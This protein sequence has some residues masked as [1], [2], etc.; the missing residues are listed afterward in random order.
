V[1]AQIDRRTNT[2][3]CVI[4]RV[5]ARGEGIWE[6]ANAARRHSDSVITGSTDSR[7][8]GAFRV[9]GLVHLVGCN[10]PSS[11]SSSY[12]TYVYILLVRAHRVYRGTGALARIVPEPG[13]SCRT[14]RYTSPDRIQYSRSCPCPLPRPSETPTLPFPHYIVIIVDI[15][16]STGEDHTPPGRRRGIT[17]PS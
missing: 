16:T 3:V 5:C 13:R 4:A 15:I 14:T 11:S 7:R 6:R 8:I 1:R 9:S 12:G 10:C 17:P 2:C